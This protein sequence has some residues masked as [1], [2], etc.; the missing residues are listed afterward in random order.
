MNNDVHV[1]TITGIRFYPFRPEPSMICLFD[2]ASHLANICRFG[3]ACPFYSVGQHSVLVSERVMELARQHDEL[4]RRDGADALIRYAGLRAGMHDAEEAYPPGDVI[5]PLK[6][7]G[8]PGIE[9][10]LEVQAAC[11]AAIAERFQLRG[12]YAPEVE[13]AIDD[14]IKRADREALLTEDRDIRHPNWLAS[15]RHLAH[16]PPAPDDPIQ[17]FRHVIKTCWQPATARLRFL[18]QFAKCSDEPV[19][20]ELRA[21]LGEDPFSEYP[22]DEVLIQRL[23][24]QEA[25]RFRPQSI[26]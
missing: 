5:G 14:L 24:L 18:Y 19:L 10:L 22:S 23:L 25:V 16:E 7:A 2:I 12:R 4:R 8:H 26:S 1:T 17:P 21:L 20:D 11:A 13:W 6:R 9:A 15:N 3:G